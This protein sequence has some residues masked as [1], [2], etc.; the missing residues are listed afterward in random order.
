M[1][2]VEAPLEVISPALRV[3]ENF[4]LF[5]PTYRLVGWREDIFPPHLDFSDLSVSLFRNQGFKSTYLGMQLNN[6]VVG[7]PFLF[8]GIPAGRVQHGIRF[9]FSKPLAA[10]IFRSP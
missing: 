3:G 9:R 6:L 7:L 10:S 1:Q 8:S 4:T 2:S 5:A